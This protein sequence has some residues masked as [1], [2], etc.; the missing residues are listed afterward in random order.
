MPKI[1]KNKDEGESERRKQS[2]RHDP[3]ARPSLLEQ[4]DGEEI[5]IRQPR[6]NTK[7]K[8]KQRIYQKMKRVTEE[9]AKD[10]NDIETFDDIADHSVARQVQLQAMDIREEEAGNNAEE[11][12]EDELSYDS[13]DAQSTYSAK[14][15]VDDYQ[16]Y[17]HEE[18]LITEE[19]EAA[20]SSF[21]NPAA[22]KV[23][24]IAD[25]IEEKLQQRKSTAEL[26]GLSGSTSRI[27]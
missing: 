23:R 21:L 27:I 22:V 10:G 18:Q 6:G 26:A 12:D 3:L 5:K 4:M 16:Q 2:T 8:V 11:K 13:D 19:E 7:R 24:T 20:F 9:D 14:S 25:L 1:L 15:G 17:L